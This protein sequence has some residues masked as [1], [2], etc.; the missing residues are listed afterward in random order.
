[1][2]RWV[3]HADLVEVSPCPR[4]VWLNFSLVEIFRNFPLAPSHALLIY[5]KLTL[6]LSIFQRKSER[7]MFLLILLTTLVVKYSARFYP[8]WSVFRVLVSKSVR[9]ISV[10]R[11]IGKGQWY[12]HKCHTKFWSISCRS[13]TKLMSKLENVFFILQHLSVFWLQ[14]LNEL[15]NLKSI[16]RFVSKKQMLQIRVFSITVLSRN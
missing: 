13:L 15:T 7:L 11:K 2:P 3:W 1:M 6:K 10:L 5:H 14:L 9:W 16:E 12:S 8:F 4:A